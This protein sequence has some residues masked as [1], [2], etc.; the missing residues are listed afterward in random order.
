MNTIN[1][2]PLKTH[3]AHAQA[4]SDELEKLA[5]IER[6][7]KA[8]IDEVLADGKI[9]DEREQQKLSSARLRL[10]LCPARRKKLLESQPK[11]SIELNDEL[12]ARRSEW[13]RLVAQRRDE[14]RAEV[15]SALTPFFPDAKRELKK[16]VEELR[17]PAVL[18]VQRAM[19]GGS[20]H[21]REAKCEALVVEARNFVA[22]VQRFA[23][24]I[25]VS[26]SES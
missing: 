25:G 19:D 8:V 18:A 22:S 24:L 5:R 17:V 20:W 26:A 11:L 12:R 7:A 9:E 2:T 13:N 3:I 15:V 4:A 21:G 23:K 10:D 1:L 16:L 6:D 14:V